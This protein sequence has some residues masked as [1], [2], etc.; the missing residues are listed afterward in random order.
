MRG[1]LTGVL[2]MNDVIRR[3]I[4]RANTVQVEGAPGADR[5][6]RLV[7]ARAARDAMGLDLEFRSMTIQ[8]HSLAE[9][10]ELPPDRALL[11]LLDGPS[12]GLGL[13]VLSAPVMSALIEM[14][15]LGKVS[16]QPAVTRKPTRTDAAMVAG[17][18]D[19][20]LAG[21]EETLAEEAD[22]VWA[23]AFRYASFLDDARPLGLLLEEESYRVLVA[24]VALA[25]GAKTGV[26]ILALP[27]IGRGVRPAAQRNS[28]DDMAGP[29][30]SATLGAQ[31]MEAGCTL[32][33]V[34]ARVTLP[35]RQVMALSAG[36]LLPLAHAAIDAVS[37]ETTGGRR[38]TAAKLGQNRGMRALKLREAAMAG[39]AAPSDTAILP[40]G[41]PHPPMTQSA[42]WRAAG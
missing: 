37:L 18:I 22:L 40:K 5:G 21:L 31:V 34:I 27:A 10:L 7:L 41:E 30:F 15:T 23:G 8:R 25:G 36:D 26:V 32:D 29:Q 3:K 19:R 1:T 33:A 39:G 4:D 38:I 24:E 9:L 13:L 2:K 16:T 11:A 35:I 6:W 28:G 20:A 12:A 17:V 42:D 14:Q